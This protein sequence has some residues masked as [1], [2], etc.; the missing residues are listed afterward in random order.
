MNQDTIQ[1]LVDGMSAQMQ[2]DRAATQMTLGELISFLKHNAD[3][4][5]PVKGVSGTCRSYRGYYEDLAFDPGSTTAGKLLD[6]AQ[7][8]LGATFIGYKGG[9]YTMRKNTPVWVSEYGT[10]GV[11]LVDLIWQDGEIVTVTTEDTYD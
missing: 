8:A 7:S 2:N 10:T 11:K 3:Y 5:D 9:E 6:S 1:Q 4:D